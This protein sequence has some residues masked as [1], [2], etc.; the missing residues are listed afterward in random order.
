MT[1]EQML[2]AISDALDEGLSDQTVK[3]MYNAMTDGDFYT[4]PAEPPPESER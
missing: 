4:Q 1:T 2:Q 3:R